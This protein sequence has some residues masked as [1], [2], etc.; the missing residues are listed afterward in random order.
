MNNVNIVIFKTTVKNPQKITPFYNEGIDYSKPTIRMLLL[1][2]KDNAKSHY[3]YIKH[4]SGLFRYQ[5]NMHN[6]KI[7]VCDNCCKCC[8]SEKALVNH[9]M[10]GCNQHAPAKLILPQKGVND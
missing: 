6:E 9:H 4:I 7:F 5:C 8:S 10:L 1:E 2:D 3:V